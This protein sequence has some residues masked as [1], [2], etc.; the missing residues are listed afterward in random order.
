MG[1]YDTMSP[2]VLF[3]FVGVRFWWCAE[4]ARYIFSSGGSGT[5]CS[6]TIVFQ[7][8]GVPRHTPTRL[9]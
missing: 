4:V 3:C 1:G 2:L 7:A 5:V 9:L 6:K 8:A